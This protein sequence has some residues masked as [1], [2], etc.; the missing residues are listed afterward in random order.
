VTLGRERLKY[1]KQFE[2]IQITLENEEFIE[3]MTQEKRDIVKIS[4][5]HIERKKNDSN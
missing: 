4:K 5:Q 2:E 1:Q 3:Q